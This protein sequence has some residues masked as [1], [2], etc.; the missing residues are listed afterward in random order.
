MNERILI[1]AAHPDDE[2][3]GCGGTIAKHSAAGDIVQ[4]LIV[5]EGV[6]S[7]GQS[8]DRQSE[9]LKLRSLMHASERAAVILGAQKPI[10]LGLPDNRMDSM[11]RL[12][13]IKEIEAVID[14]YCPSRIYT[15]HAGDLNVDHRRVHEAVVTATRPTPGCK[16]GTILTFEV[17]SSTEWQ[18]PAS[19]PSFRPS[20]YVDISDHLKQKLDA[21]KVYDMEMREWPH[22]RSLKAAEFNTRLR[23]SQIGRDAAEAFML[24]RQVV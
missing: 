21:L 5:A 8:D 12:D 2:V 14:R 19:G 7:R 15:H 3:L 22:A 13:I 6:T 9:G 4:I 18:S 23:G 20:F 24:I 11:D 16:V 1:V 10:F 17:Q